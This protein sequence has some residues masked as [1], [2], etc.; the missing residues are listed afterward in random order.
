MKLYCSHND[1]PSRSDL[2]HA[3][4]G[5]QNQRKHK[6]ISIGYLV[7]QK[8]KR[9]VIEQLTS[10]SVQQFGVNVQ[11][12]D[13]TTSDRDDIDLVLHK[14]DSF[15]EDRDPKAKIL[16]R[17]EKRLRTAAFFD[18]IS[19]VQK[20]QRRDRT[21]EALQDVK[22]MVDGDVIVPSFVRASSTCTFDE[23]EKKMRENS[24]SYP[25]LCKPNDSTSHGIC[26]VLSREGLQKCVQGGEVLLQQFIPHGGVLFKVDVLG[27]TYTVSPRN[28]LDME[29]IDA[30]LKSGISH[31][32]FFGRVSAGSISRKESEV[33]GKRAVRKQCQ[34]PPQALVTRVTQA[35]RA[36]FGLNLFNFDWIVEEGR[37]QHH[38]VDVNYFAGYKDTDHLAS[39]LL[40]VLLQAVGGVETTLQA[41]GRVESTRSAD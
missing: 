39:R 26:L 27:G 35:M 24:I 12:I 23:I 16:H 38:I 31:V 32:W 3:L 11:F 17:L 6:R 40:Y 10:F 20:L 29:D 2:D 5:A 18:H 30:A 28:S 37:Q 13:L 15:A 9:R 1:E 25:V 14:L 7:G 19:N 22:R 8:K 34:P 36:V 21:F 4:E 41:V 33:L